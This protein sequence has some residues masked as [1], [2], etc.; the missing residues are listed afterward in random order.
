MTI[1]VDL[2]YIN[3]K[4]T[5]GVTNYSYRLLEG[6]KQCGF[7]KNITLLVTPQNSRTISEQADGFRQIILS[8]RNIRIIPHLTGI[9]NKK[10]VN[11]LVSLYNFD[12]FFSPYIAFHGL[13]TTIIPSIGVFHDAQG[14]SLKHNKLKQFA[15]NFFSRRILKRQTVVVTIS[16]FAQ[17]DI[18]Q[19]VPSIKGRIK[20][21]YNSILPISNIQCK[22]ALFPPYILNVNTLEPY[23]N[24]ITLVKAFAILKNKIPHSLY[25]KAKR[26]PYWDNVVYPFIIKEKIENR[27]LLIEQQYS[28][29]E[30]A[31]LYKNASLFVSPSLMEGFGFTPIEAALYEIPVI[32][33][34]ESALYET[35]KGLLNYYEP[36]TDE[37]AL[38]RIM[39]D[40][41]TSSSLDLKTIAKTYETT[42]SVKRQAQDFIVLFN[43]ILSKN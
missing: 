40:V 35:T 25:I 41:L 21:I 32:C 37:C 38:S 19:K 18:A 34:K 28:E 17:Q 22:N 1:L 9:L 16:H 14:F 39:Y 30:M 29:E 7:E 11:R 15:Y 5:A 10:E 36:G 12:I 23:K 3:P 4:E 13:Y 24:L 42:Y 33:N 6:F 26:R 8:L 31:L 2:T 43:T 27:V 20:V